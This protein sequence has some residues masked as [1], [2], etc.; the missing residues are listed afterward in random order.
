MKNCNCEQLFAKYLCDIPNQWREGIVKALC[1]IFEDAPLNCNDVKKC[2][3]LTSLSPFSIS[4]DI[5]S[6]VFHDEKGRNIKRSLDLKKVINGVLNQ[7]DPLCIMSIDSWRLL[8]F[9]QKLQTL[10]NLQCNQ[11]CV[12]TT[13]TT[14]SSSTTSTT[15]DPCSCHTYQI[16]NLSGKNIDMFYYNCSTYNQVY[17]IV[18]NGETTQICS[19]SNW[20]KPAGAGITVI[21]LGS[22]CFATT[23]TSTSTTTTV[24]PTTT[25][26]TSTTSTTTLVPPTTTTTTSTSTTS[27]S[28][29]STSSTTSTSTSSTSTSTS[30]T[31]TTTAA[32]ILCRSYSIQ[33]TPTVSIEWEDCPTGAILSTTI[34]S[35]GTQTF[36]IREG[37]LNVTGGS[38]EIID[39]GPC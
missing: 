7:I 24:P 2:E 39:L 5:L 10:I 28:S 14:T 25:T 23:S 20:T 31:T 1:F 19:C 34:T 12:N 33:A 16:R 21:N 27:T 26:S 32:P 22:G 3:T 8:S 18:T 17:Q 15:T 38:A 36:C 35:G 13:T 4:G 37:S 11:C 6:V 30:T 29:T 9:E